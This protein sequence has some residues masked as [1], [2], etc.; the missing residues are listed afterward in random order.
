MIAVSVMTFGTN[1]NLSLPLS[2]GGGGTTLDSR[3]GEPSDATEA[4]TPG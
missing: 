3:S 4:G 2:S 1:R